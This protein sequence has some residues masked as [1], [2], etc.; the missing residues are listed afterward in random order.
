MRTGVRLPRPLPRDA[1]PRATSGAH[2]RCAARRLRTRRATYRKKE[3]STLQRLPRRFFI[4][5]VHTGRVL[6]PHGNAVSSRLDVSMA[7]E[8][9]ENR[10][11]EEKEVQIC[12]RGIDS[13]KR[14]SA[15]LRS[16]GGHFKRLGW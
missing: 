15:F 9:K 14:S 2:S 5:H 7:V 10:E 12:T 6:T 16:A 1:A 4:F 13:V 11:T 8:E 3:T